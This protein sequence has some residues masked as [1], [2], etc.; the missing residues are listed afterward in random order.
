MFSDR[1]NPTRFRYGA[2]VLLQPATFFRRSAYERAGGFRQ[3]GRV[4][5]D[6]ELWAALA[7][8]G[9]RFGTLDANLAAFRLHPYSL[10]GDP[11]QQQR[12]R[13]DARAVER[14]LGSGPETL[15][16]QLFRVFFRA[17]KFVRHPVKSLRRRAFFYSILK[18]WSL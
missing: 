7:A 12:R 14:E 5:W 6:M 13:D 10:T 18:R 17:T 11:A 3:S 9:A 16:D 15:Q 4:C 1:W 8:T 2:C